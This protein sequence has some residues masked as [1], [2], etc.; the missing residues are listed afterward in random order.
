M[1]GTNGSASTVVNR[2]ELVELR[3]KETVPPPKRTTESSQHT[4]A[5]L[6]A[7]RASPVDA[8]YYLA[9]VQPLREHDSMHAVDLVETLDA[10]LQCNGNVTHTAK[11]LFLHR[12]TLI[13]RLERIKA[14]IDVD[15]NDAQVRLA[16][17]VALLLG[18]EV[19][20]GDG[21]ERRPDGT[22]RPAD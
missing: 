18:E 5:L 4:G 8:A 10:Y 11:M 21:N 12:S 3:R 19:G 6:R 17:Q 22:P 9:L 16:L 13:H 1:T 7:L 14:L 20:S 15:I 2:A